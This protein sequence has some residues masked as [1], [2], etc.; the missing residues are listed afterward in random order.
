MSSR[1]FLIVICTLLLSAPGRADTPPQQPIEKSPVLIDTDIGDEIDDALAL[2]LALVSPELDVR[3][4][5]TVTGDSFTRA[6]LV[7]NLLHHAG[8]KDIAVAAADKRRKLP[9]PTGQLQYGL[10]PARYAPQPTN[11]I[12][13]LYEQLKKQPGHFTVVALGPLTN[14]ADLLT[15]HPDC[16]P[17][18]KRIVLMGGAVRV[19]YHG[20]SPPEPEWNFKSD[21]KAAQTVFAAGVPLTVAPL[22][23]TATL[24]LTPKERDRLLLHGNPVNRELRILLNLREKKTPVLFDPVAVTLCFEP[25]FFKMEKLRVAV[26]DRGMTRVVAGKPNALV[27]TAVDKQK[28]L[29][30]YL[31]RLAPPGAKPA[32]P[33]K[34]AWTNVVKPVPV[35]A[36]PDRVHVVE[37]FQ[38]DIERRWWLCGLL[39]SERGTDGDR[40]YLR[41]ALTH[42]FDD[43]MGDPKA[44]YQAVI[45]NP[46]PGPP[47]GK[48]TRLSFRYRI[49]G[50]TALRVQIYSLSKGYHRHLTLQDLPEGRWQSITVDLREARRP[51]GSGGPLAAD[52]RID[53]VQF[54]T[55]AA[56]ELFIDDLVLYDQ[57]VAGESRPFP[58]GIGFTAWFDTGKQGEEWPGDFVI[59]AKKGPNGWKAAHSIYDAKEQR[60]W[61]RLGLRGPRPLADC[62]HLRFR[63]HLTATGTIRLLLRH[64]AGKERHEVLLENL[65]PNGWN[66]V[67]VE[68]CPAGKLRRGA[69]VNELHFSVGAECALVIDDV[70]L[71]SPGQA[72]E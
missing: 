52:E 3:G 46:V 59:V 43:L 8:R 37:N 29:A 11:A 4:I 62:T 65:K 28:Y 53:D 30:W 5:T 68:L 15:K 2:A 14:V 66:E 47:M 17:W 61:I 70:L 64:S 1:T 33:D 57:A 50:A 21:P 19:G 16:K 10:R 40:R 35:G 32:P 67:T 45:F 9:D 60:H 48:Q 12:D 20:K 69:A 25:K 41:A 71:F 49:Q 72:K 34:I 55:D 31:D 24:D 27:A 39:A 23:A 26:D 38:T 44:L 63:Y 54:Y 13:F 58:K 18:I 36:F 6:Q 7:C 42:D 51:D 22:D 56:A